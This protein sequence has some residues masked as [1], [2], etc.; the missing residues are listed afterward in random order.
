M[1]DHGGGLIGGTVVE[2]YPAGYTDR[3][4]DWP[5]KDAEGHI[6]RCELCADAPVVAAMG[7][8]EEG[9]SLRWRRHVSVR[10]RGEDGAL[11]RRYQR[12]VPRQSIRGMRG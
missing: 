12:F 9:K 7:L 11:Y 1:D 6:D 8:I 2:N 3:G 5:R 10:G 4:G